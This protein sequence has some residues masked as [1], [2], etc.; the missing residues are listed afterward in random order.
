MKKKKTT[1]S[2]DHKFPIA[3]VLRQGFSLK[4]RN[5]M[6]FYEKHHTFSPMKIMQHRL[7]CDNI[8]ITKNN[9]KKKQQNQQITNSRLHVFYDRASD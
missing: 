9:G 3:R 1:Y 2:A 4:T 8:I 6:N 5:Q 7:T